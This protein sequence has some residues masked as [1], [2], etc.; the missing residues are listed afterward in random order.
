LTLYFKAIGSA[1]S[2][3]KPMSDVDYL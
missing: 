3:V 2:S 1:L